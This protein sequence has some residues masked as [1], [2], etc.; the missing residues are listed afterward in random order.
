MTELQYIRWTLFVCT[1]WTAHCTAV[2]KDCTTHPR[3]M[4]DSNN[5]KMEREGSGVPHFPPLGLCLST[6]TGG[7]IIC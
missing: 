6:N 2:V 4:T 7:F 3:G 5:C 1:I